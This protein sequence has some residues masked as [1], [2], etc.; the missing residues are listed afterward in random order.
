M[1]AGAAGLAILAALSGATLAV[2]PAEAS[3]SN[4]GPLVETSQGIQTRSVVLAVD[5]TIAAGTSADISLTLEGDLDS[6]NETI[7]VR[8]DGVS[9][10][11]VNGTQCGFF[12]RNISVSAATLS[13]LIAD[14]QITLSFTSTAQVNINC[15]GTGAF[16]GIGPFFFAAQGTLTYQ[17]GGKAVTVISQFMRQRNNLLLSNEPDTGRQIDRL[18]DMEA[19]GEQTGPGLAAAP[20]GSAAEF[21]EARQIGGITRNPLSYRERMS[22]SAADDNPFLPPSGR[23][24]TSEIAALLPRAR[25]SSDDPVR[26]DFVASLS[27]MRRLSA[28]AD[29]KK[30][31]GLSPD[32]GMAADAGTVP[33]VRPPFSPFDIWVQGKYARINDRTSND[34]DGHFGVLSIGTD[35]V[36][37]RQLLVG[38]VVQFDSMRQQSDQQSTEMSGVG[39]MAGPYAT[40]RLTDNLF[41][42]GRAAWG[43]SNNDVSPLNT[44][45]DTFDS[46]R[47]LVSTTL[48]GQWRHGPWL[49]RPSLSVAYMDDAAESY[50]DGVG[51]F[52]QAV[53]AKLGQAKAGP[54]ILYRYQYSPDLVV[55]PH[56]RFQVIWNFA[57]EAE[58]T[59]L[60]LIEGRSAEVRGR[61][62]IGM[63]MLSSDGMALDLSAGYDGI[64]ADTFDALM[65]TA[66]LR[67]PLN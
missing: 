5:N 54:E 15:G 37:S 30:R 43:R 38:A 22:A 9:V 40:L 18:N 55:E 53:T 23:G 45:T 20:A 51:A 11:I 49:F 17:A 6:V 67:V 28:E 29:Q 12:T 7:D 27:Q 21:A 47:W 59:G 56:A 19:S 48:T 46:T 64:G 8:I 1:R 58:A 41:W 50:T 25:A 42:Q 39:W 13:P 62:E 60:A 16:T 65:A 61:V 44:Y 36:L 3:T 34:L 10:G 66:T 32:G 52:T 26:F 4:F 33:Y 31:M 57:D 35:Y 14:G 24:A 2:R 63:H